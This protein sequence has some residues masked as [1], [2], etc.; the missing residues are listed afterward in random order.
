MNLGKGEDLKQ[1]YTKNDVPVEH[2]PEGRYQEGGNR[3]GSS[4]TTMRIDNGRQYY[5]MRVG[6]LDG[7]WSVQW[8]NAGNLRRR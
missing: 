7:P 1:W 3:I 2:L 8:I 6:P 4:P 5:L